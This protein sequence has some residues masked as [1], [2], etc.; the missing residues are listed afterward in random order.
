MAWSAQALTFGVLSGPQGSRD[1]YDFGAPTALTSVF[2]SS[3]PLRGS[4]GHR[5]S[6]TT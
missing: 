5:T 4:P 2:L 1:P 6:K 3:F